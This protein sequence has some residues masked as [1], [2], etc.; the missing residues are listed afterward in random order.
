MPLLEPGGNW[1]ALEEK[2]GSVLMIKI[3]LGRRAGAAHA[4]CSRTD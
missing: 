4:L 2:N 3:K 1:L